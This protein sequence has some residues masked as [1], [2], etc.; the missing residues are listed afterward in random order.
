MRLRTKI[1]TFGVGAALVGGM[2]AGSAMVAGAAETPPGDF[3]AAINGSG[4]AG[5]TLGITRIGNAKQCYANA[6]EIDV[7]IN[8]ARWLDS[9]NNKGC[10]RWTVQKREK[11][12]NSESWV[13]VTFN[14]KDCFEKNQ[15]VNFVTGA[16]VT[17]IFIN[18]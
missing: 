1:A 3:S 4:C 17:K 18:N 5:G 2:I 7:R 9:G 14:G 16:R 15:R 13:T 11:A 8:D 10:V 12:P 6:G